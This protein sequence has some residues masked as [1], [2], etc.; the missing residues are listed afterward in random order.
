MFLYEKDIPKYIEH[1][2][3]TLPDS[4]LKCIKG[5]ESLNLVTGEVTFIPFEMDDNKSDN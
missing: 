5:V 4:M 2:K 3:K 1:I